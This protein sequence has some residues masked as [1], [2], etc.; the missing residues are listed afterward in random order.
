MYGTAF[1]GSTKIHRTSSAGCFR[2]E[3]NLISGSFTIIGIEHFADRVYIN[4]KCIL[5][6]GIA[7]GE[8]SVVFCS[9]ESIL[10]PKW[11]SMFLSDIWQ[12]KVSCLV[13]NEVHCLSEWGEEFRPDYKEMAQLRSFFNVPVLALTATSTPKIKD[14]VV[15]ILQLEDEKTVIVSRSADRPNIYT[16]CQ[17]KIF[18][19]YEQE[20]EWLVNHIREHGTNSKKTIIYCRSIDTVSQI[21]IFLKAA[22]EEYAYVDKIPNVENLLI[23]MFHKCTHDTSKQRILSNFS[24]VNSSIRCIVATVALGMGIDIPDVRLVVHIGCPKSVISYWQKA[25]RCAR[26]GQQGYS[27]ILYDNFTAALKTTDK[28]MSQLVKNAAEK[29]IRQQILDVF[30]CVMKNQCQNSHVTDVT[31]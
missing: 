31:Q 29:C 10:K 17:K 5:P 15:S 2:S 21:F 7:R 24:K 14:D 23:E 27:L 9:P 1:I 6:L 12:K 18:N 3:Q 16:S 19:D 26:D 11:R 22:L 13:F 25:G 30:L 4:C 20:L 8:Y 28:D